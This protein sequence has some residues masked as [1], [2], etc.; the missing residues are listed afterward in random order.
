ME[1]NVAFF[2]MQI[3]ARP[4]LS[5]A[6]GEK[7]GQ[8]AS[9]FLS[10]NTDTIYDKNQ[11]KQPIMYARYADDI[12]LGITIIG[13]GVMSLFLKGRLL[14]SVLLSKECN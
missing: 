9:H 14:V 2:L 3:E 13:V 10:K 7:R 1:S 12:L 11:P 6:A 4:P 8:W 5:S